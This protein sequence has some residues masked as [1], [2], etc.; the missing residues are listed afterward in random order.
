MT[1][2]TDPQRYYSGTVYRA[3]YGFVGLLLAG[4]GVYV[5][6]FGVVEPLYR[7]GAGTLMALLGVN[8]GWSA[9]HSKPSWLARLVLFI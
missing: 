5:V 7:I 4:L 9:L 3:V 8:A 1:K 6:F 2:K